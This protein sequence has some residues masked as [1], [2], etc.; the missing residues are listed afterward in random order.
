MHNYRAGVEGREA[1]RYP[2]NHVC[3][4]IDDRST[5]LASDHLPGKLIHARSY[6]SHFSI[7]G[8]SG[9]RR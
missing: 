2:H 7:H 3:A 6:C 1:L 4:V 9:R 8:R 5:M